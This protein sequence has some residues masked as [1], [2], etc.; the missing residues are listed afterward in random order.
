MSFESALVTELT[1]NAALS[2]LVGGDRVRPVFRPEEETFPCVVYTVIST[3]QMSNLAGR[4]TS[5]RNIRVQIDLWCRTH[6]DLIALA[7][8][9]KVQMNAATGFKSTLLPSGFDDYEPEMDLL[10]KVLEFSC[11]YKEA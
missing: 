8:A 11:W 7:D 5:L 2:A 10:H 6:D 4:D 1:S 9:V 3:D